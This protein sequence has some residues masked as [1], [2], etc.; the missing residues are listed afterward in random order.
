MIVRVLEEV[1]VFGGHEV[2]LLLLGRTL[3][4]LLTMKTIFLIPVNMWGLCVNMCQYVGV[5]CMCQGGNINFEF[6]C[7]CQNL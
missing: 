4:V 7:Q 5:M 2:V 1:D 6:E 3:L